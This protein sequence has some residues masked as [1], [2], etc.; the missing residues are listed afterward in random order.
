M[1]IKG[2]SDSDSDVL[3]IPLDLEEIAS[4]KQYCLT[5][6][7]VSWSLSSFLDQIANKFYQ[8]VNGTENNNICLDFASKNPVIVVDS[9]HHHKQVKVS[10]NDPSDLHVDEITGKHAHL[11]FHDNSIQKSKELCRSFSLGQ[12][13]STFQ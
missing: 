13:R 6:G 9:I 11:V 2:D 5:L 12:R 10:F 8:Q 1:T 3:T 7:D 4:F